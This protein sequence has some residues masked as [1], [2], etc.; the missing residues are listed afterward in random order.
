MLIAEGFSYCIVITYILTTQT[1]ILLPASL[2]H[3][4]TLPGQSQTPT[5]GLKAVPGAQGIV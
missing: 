4:T 1:M 5:F 2:L 3:H